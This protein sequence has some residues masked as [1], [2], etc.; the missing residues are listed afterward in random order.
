MN[1]KSAFFTVTLLIGLSGIMIA[2]SILQKGDR[3]PNFLEIDENENSINLEDYNGMV[4]LLNFTATWCG[5]C[6]ETY[7]PMNELQKRYRD[8]LVIISFH[9]DEMRE[10]W[11]RKAATKGIHFDV[12]SIWESDTKQDVFNLFSPKIYPNFVLLNQEGVITKKWEGN[13]EKHLRRYVHKAM[14]K[15]KN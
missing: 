5:P 13:S 15:F 1:I 10:K 2:Q 7:S 8:E 3:V 6:W 11:E 4:V 9:M 12:V 14:R